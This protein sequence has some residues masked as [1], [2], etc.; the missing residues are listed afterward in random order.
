MARTCHI[1]RLDDA[2]DQRLFASVTGFLGDNQPHGSLIRFPDGERM[3]RVLGE[4]SPHRKQRLF[5]GNTVLSGALCI[6]SDLL[7]LADSEMPCHS[8]GTS[9][10]QGRDRMVPELGPSLC[11]VLRICELSVSLFGDGRL[12]QAGCD[13]LRLFKNLYGNSVKLRLDGAYFRCQIKRYIST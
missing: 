8:A 13:E 2:S 1:S 10:N 4:A 5:T 3:G 9:G 6:R 11:G 7:T 12:G